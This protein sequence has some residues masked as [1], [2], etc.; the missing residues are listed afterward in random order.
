M[1]ASVR[2]AAEAFQTI[3]SR[4]AGMVYATCRRI[5]RNATDAEDM[6]QECFETLA[7]PYLSQ[8]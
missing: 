5:L 2:G 3:V 8:S 7:Q 1:S 4:H 6:A